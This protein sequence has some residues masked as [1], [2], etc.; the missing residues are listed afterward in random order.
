MNTFGK[1]T[2]K[3]RRLIT[4]TLRQWRSLVVILL[5]TVASSAVT[6][7]QP[8]PLKVLVDYAL[9][10]SIVSQSLGSFLNALP[11]AGNTALILLAAIASIT[12]F[13]TTALL[14][15][16]FTWGWASCGQRAV[17]ELAADLFHQLQRLSL[18]F[19]SKRTVGDSMS[20][21]TGDA[22]CVYTSMQVL[23]IGP[24]QH[25]LTLTT[26]GMV[27]WHL[28]PW[29]TALTFAIAP[30]QAGGAFFY[31]NRL[32]W[33]TKQNRQAHSDFVS[34]VHQTL[35]AIPMVQAF[36]AEGR[37]GRRFR[38]L[39]DDA[40]KR[41][42]LG[43]LLT[44]SYGFMNGLIITV[45]T[46][47]VLFAGAQRAAAGVLSVG[48]L[49]VFLAYMR[50]LQGASQGLLTTYASLKILD[51]STD[52][53]VEILE[54]DDP[55]Q[56]AAGAKP[57]PVLP[58][59][60]GGHIRIENVTFGYESGRP[61]L[62]EVNLEAL[63]GQTVALVGPTGAGKSTLVSL[64][65]RFYD[66]WQGRI[67]VDGIDA[68][69]I[70]ISSLR[71]RV[72]LVLQDP[73]LLPITVA[74]NIAY[75]RPDASRSDI[76]AAAV[77]A[78]ADEFIRRLPDGYDTVMAE[79]AAT[80]SGGE[81]QRIAIARAI[82]KDA[83]ILIL[84]EPTSSLDTKTESSLLEALERLMVGRTTF[85][86][87]HRLSTIRHADKIAVIE[88]GRLIEA[89][90][91]EELLAVNGHYRHVHALQFGEPTREVAG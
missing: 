51:V 62:S 28:D 26:V 46:A 33:R 60:Q 18:M 29:L 10:K 41:S 72:S 1:Q 58:S 77:V 32:K 12:L 43:T 2:L 91:H 67:V 49:L 63:P 44:S 85:I 50:A 86:I 69:E 5:L 78:N 79:R 11:V 53:V 25:L 80:L 3:Y 88:N 40:V 17:H 47:I 70:Q 14:E 35:T 65:P 34:F 89:G 21:L 68:R 23:L 8:W 57:L 6:L 7:L 83:P 9:G 19:H 81:K 87:A 15:A 36:G 66:P 90:T 16:G 30:L 20:R 24:G 52:R 48:S 76:I 42:Q 54:A 56:N 37:N 64:I 55:V 74:E 31:G 73:F 39:A 45:G 4:Y 22:Y 84:D 61:V 27:A 59:G 38:H 13:I 82:L 75:G 71:A